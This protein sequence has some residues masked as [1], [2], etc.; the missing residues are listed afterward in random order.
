MI[1][2]SVEM[3]NFMPYVGEQKVS[4]D[5]SK[6]HPVV[7]IYGE[8]N[9]GKSS[10][11]SAIKWSMYG[12][13][14]DRTGRKTP[15]ENILNDSAFDAGERTFSVTIALESDGDSYLIQRTSEVN[16]DRDG[17]R[18]STKQKVTM[19]KNSNF[20]EHVEIQPT[21]NQIMNKEISIFFLCDMEVLEDYEKL[22]KDDKLAAEGI[23]N[24][25]EDIL[26]VP[27]IVAV[28]E[29]LNAV[30]SD[31]LVEIKKNSDSSKESTRIQNEIA[32]KEGEFKK[33]KS[34]L[35]KAIAKFKE[36]ELIKEELD[37]LL[38]KHEQSAELIGIEK[39]LLDQE[40]SDLKE[41]ERLRL[42]I[43][44]AMRESWWLPISHLVESKYAETQTATEIAASR[45]STLSAKNSRLK[46]LSESLESGS[47]GE[48]GQSIPDAGKMEIQDQIEKL[49]VEITE[50]QIPMVPSLESLME[51]SKKLARFR[52]P[53]K[54]AIIRS[55]EKSIRL[56][57][58]ENMKRRQRLKD[59]SGQ[60]DGIDKSEV[61][62]L[63]AKRHTVATEIGITLKSIKD[64]NFK[65]SEAEKE[66]TALQV[67]FSKIQS[68][69]DVNEITIEHAISSYLALVFEKAVQNF[70]ETTKRE[71]EK[72]ASEIFKKLVSKNAFSNLEINENYGLR[73]VD[74]SGRSFD[75]R[76]AGVEQVVAL[77]LI[78]ALGR[79]AV[80]SGCLVLD[81]PFARL[82]EVHRDNILKYL[83]L[84]SEQVILLLQSGEKL[85]RSAS[86]DLLPR[87]ANSYQISIG[88]SPKESFIRKAV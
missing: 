47:C 48:C 10:L 81:T 32:L 44:L 85:S 30:S 86:D 33:A 27:A 62:Q 59:I 20:V 60:L 69:V 43:L 12:E 50:L 38:A 64:E 41:I 39:T 2:R 18:I 54:A 36:K 40:A 52:V 19:R 83:P 16:V 4:F 24:A 11:F 55:H 15:E 26:G 66:I 71:V 1:I 57:L 68:V 7:L 13:H 28:R 88:K 76:G 70:R 51:E 23:K 46:A 73:L 78:L 53:P 8:N 63:N 35:G 82:D 80:R 34:E 75:H 87:V 25:I 58:N 3:L 49:K 67:K 14:I 37:K 21:I 72:A 84:E 61:Q 29:G 77:S 65:A 45:N 5:T 56:L 79:K 9:R 17:K 42:E 74:D 22:V 31:A 6:E